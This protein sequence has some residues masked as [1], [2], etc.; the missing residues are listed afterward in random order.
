MKTT[1]TEPTP[2][3]STESLL[4]SF[5]GGFLPLIS[6]DPADKATDITGEDNVYDRQDVLRIKRLGLAAGADDVESKR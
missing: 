3:S 2:A 4:M 1:T 6:G 5:L